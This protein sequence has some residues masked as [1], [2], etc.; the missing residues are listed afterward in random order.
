MLLDKFKKDNGPALDEKTAG[1]MLENI[2]DACEVE[3]NSVPL[4]VLTSYSNYR[5]ERFLL[6]RI[7]LGVIMLC[8]CLVPLLFIA[9]DIELN[10]L[11][12]G[13]K[14]KPSY[15]LTVNSLIP[16][17]R[18]TATLDGKYVPVYEVGDKTYSVE[19][20]SNGTMTVTV[21]LKNRQ[22]SSES[23][24]VTGV[25][26]SSPIVLSD[27]LEGNQVYLYMSDLDSGVDYESISAMDID[28]KEVLPAFYDESEN[29]VVFDYPEK[30]LNIYI[31][32]KVGNTLQLIL[33]VKE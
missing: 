16:V 20:V 17:S 11:D 4:S 9:P 10:P 1:Q 5:R 14:G 13:V 27:R 23:F 19:P 29:Y 28:G 6:Q 31:S 33:T 12:S 15:E 21:T 30:S 24:N 3:P 8:F 26:T 18:V 2:F 32:D 7:L 22:F 25:D